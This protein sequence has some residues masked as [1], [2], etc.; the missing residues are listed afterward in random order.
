M[1]WTISPYFNPAGYASRLRNFRIFRANLASPLAV[2]EWSADGNFELSQ[3]D[4]DIVLQIAGGDVMW[5]KERLLNLALRSLPGDCDKVAW[6]DCDVIFA[7]ANWAEQAEKAL[8]RYSLVQPFRRRCNLSSGAEATAASSGPFDSSNTSVGYKIALGQADANDFRRNNAP[9][10][11]NSTNGLAWAARRDVLEAHGL[12]DACIL[13]SGDRVLLIA[14]V[15]Q[16]HYAAQ[17]NGM[18]PRQ[19]EHYMAWAE[20]FHRAMGGRVGYVDGSLLHLW[21]GDPKDRKYR[22]RHEGFHRFEFDPFN[23]IA[24]APSGCWRWNGNKQEMHE[25]V[26]RY[27]EDRKEDGQQAPRRRAASNTFAEGRIDSDRS[28]VQQHV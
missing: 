4:A 18:H 28:M 11:Q 22:E 27:F 13:G 6:V 8:E 26:R 12:Y 25:Y 14:A 7:A 10:S 9:P 15:G 17:V 2:V 1:L 19:F 20:P 21:H 3:D 16:F 24:L 5:Q 23:D